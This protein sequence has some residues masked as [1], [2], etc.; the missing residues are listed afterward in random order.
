[1]GFVSNG[2]ISKFSFED[3]VLVKFE[4]AMTTIWLT[5]D[6]LIV[7]ANNSQNTNYTDSYA[8]T[9]EIT[10]SGTEIIA[11][12]KEGYSRYDADDKLIEEVPDEPVA[13]DEYHTVFKEIAGAYLATFEYVDDEYVLEFEIPDEVGAIGDTYELHVKASDITVTWDRYLNR[14]QR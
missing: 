5:V 12:L 11:L 6:A 7:K 14:V 3:A 4:R 1:M 13:P 8:D 2:E 10:L 9:A